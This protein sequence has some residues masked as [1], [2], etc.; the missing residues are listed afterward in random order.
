MGSWED[1]KAHGARPDLIGLGEMLPHFLANNSRP[2]RSHVCPREFLAFKRKR[3]S[4]GFCQR[5]GEAVAEI[6]FGGVAAGFSEVAIS[7]ARDPG[8]RVCDWLNRNLRH[9]DQFIKT[10]AG[11]RDNLLMT[12]RGE[13]RSRGNA[14][15][16][17]LEEPG[18][19]FFH[20]QDAIFDPRRLGFF[21][22]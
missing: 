13:L 7:L 14:P 11:N 22:Q 5:V 4:F 3:L 17:G 16:V 20:H 19:A 21:L 8:L 18:H 1:K 12:T 15:I 6:Q 2:R 10:A 9:F